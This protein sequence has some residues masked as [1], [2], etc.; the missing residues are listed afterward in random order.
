MRGVKLYGG[1]V[2]TPG[3]VIVR[4]CGTRWNPG[5]GVGMGRDFTLFATVAG[6]VKFDKG[7]K[8]RVSIVPFPVKTDEPAADAATT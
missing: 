4:Q 2:A 1:Q 7:S 3:S 6:H 5:K 8:R